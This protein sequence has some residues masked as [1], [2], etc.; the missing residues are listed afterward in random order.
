MLT[1]KRKEKKTKAI[2]IEGSKFVSGHERY[3]YLWVGFLFCAYLSFRRSYLKMYLVAK[4]FTTLRVTWRKIK[5]KR[6]WKEKYFGVSQYPFLPSVRPIWISK[7]CYLSKVILFPW[8]INLIITQ[9][10]AVFPVIKPTYYC[11]HKLSYHFS[12]FIKLRFFAI[13]NFN[14]GLRSVKLEPRKLYCL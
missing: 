10:S 6:N 3:I 13:T 1:Q 11:H 2:S 4:A 7:T 14:R 8:S 12:I 5:K 9:A